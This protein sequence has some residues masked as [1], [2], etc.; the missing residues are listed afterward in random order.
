MN[1]CQITR[2]IYSHQV[3]EVWSRNN[4]QITFPNFL[5]I[6]SR[7]ITYSSKQNG[8]PSTAGHNL[9]STEVCK[10]WGKI[11]KIKKCACTSWGLK[12]QELPEVG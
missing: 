12:P 1:W 4:L 6:I 11:L 9:L 8:I 10:Y 3:E 5:E 2:V 7:F